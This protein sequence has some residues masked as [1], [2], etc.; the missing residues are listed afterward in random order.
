M[1]VYAKNPCLRSD[2]PIGAVHQRDAALAR[3]ADL[4]GA[5][6]RIK[7][8][9]FRLLG[10]TTFEKRLEKERAA[11]LLALSSSRAQGGNTHGR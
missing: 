5:Q 6:E 1:T 10:A 3:C 9:A 8:A 2:C 4:E 11:L 7:V